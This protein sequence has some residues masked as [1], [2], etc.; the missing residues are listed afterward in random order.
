MFRTIIDGACSPV[1][2][3]PVTT[4]QEGKHAWGDLT[5]TVV[6]IGHKLEIPFDC[7]VG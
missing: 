1:Y 2:Y 3:Q 7:G 6:R 5:V 4:V